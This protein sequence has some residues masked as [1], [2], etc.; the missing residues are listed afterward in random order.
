VLLGGE[1]QQQFAGGGGDPPELGGHHGRRLAAGRP[2]VERRQLRVGHHQADAGRRHAQ[3][4]RDHLGQGRA[5]V[6]ADLDLAGEGRHRAVL[7]D[8][9]PGPDLLG[10]RPPWGTLPPLRGRLLGGGLTQQQGHDDAAAGE[11][12]EAPPAQLEAG[13]GILEELIALGFE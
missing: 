9:Q 12:E 1:G 7:A 6:L 2:E 3:L 8:V 5:D 10:Q 4:L 13:P 11:P